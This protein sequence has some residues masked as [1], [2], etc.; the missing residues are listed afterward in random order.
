MEKKI[1]F[2]TVKNISAKDKWKLGQHGFVVIEVKFLSEIKYA[3][4]LEGNLM[5]ESAMTAL[6]KSCSTTVQ[7]DFFKEMYK[8]L[9]MKK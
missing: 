7:A 4:A 3:T 9:Y 2:T 8:K 5:L 1:I 6:D